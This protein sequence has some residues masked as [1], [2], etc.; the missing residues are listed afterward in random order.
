MSC[1]T[2]P[3]AT[4]YTTV[5]SE[6]LSTSFSNEVTTL[7]ASVTTIVSDSCLA[8]GTVGNSTGCIS[9][10]EVTAVS[11]IAAGSES[12][13][14]VP[15]VLTIT[16]TQ[17]QATATLYSTSCSNGD[18]TQPPTSPPTPP[19]TSPTP[20][21]SDTSH[22]SSS[23]TSFTTSSVLTTST[24]MS[25]YT[26]S[27]ATTLADGAVVTTVLTL[28]STGTPTAVYVP[29]SVPATPQSN[30]G[31]SGGSH[32]N[33]ALA[34]II[35]GTIGGVVGLLAL[36]GIIWLMWRR[37]RYNFDDIFNDGPDDTP[38]HP[39]ERAKS[40]TLDL[41][42]EPK[43]YQYGLVGASTPPLSADH[44]SQTT[45]DTLA[46]SPTMGAGTNPASPNAHGRN[47]SLTP[48]M[49][50]GAM[51]SPS[52][53]QPH[54]AS[55]RP[56]TSGSMQPLIQ[57]QQVYHPG[58]TAQPALAEWNPNTDGL[59]LGSDIGYEF[60]SAQSVGSGT[61]QE[62]HRRRMLLV[63]NPETRPMSPA[64]VA[65]GSESASTRGEKASYR[66]RRESASVV[67]HR[68]GGRAPQSPPGPSASGSGANR[69]SGEA[70][71]PAYSD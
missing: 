32:S 27:A 24:P 52:H 60:G 41:G 68:D 45:A 38:A 30:Q 21:P 17:T 11:T 29:T 7:P 44:H 18:T 54:T 48:L 26:T 4:Q 65:A 64:S 71:P 46:V 69:G 9:S 55:S 15:A 47:N 1:N 37:R 62:E 13:V 20:P 49:V 63:A 8:T 43:P 58:P 59:G 66:P 51:L 12:T 22:S 10:T 2:V 25:T 19:P 35:G 57:Q 6:S 39:V 56:S 33:V 14:Q 31:G 34:P 23:S 50:T 53:S 42:S 28:T 70:P 3:T 40:R 61:A 16:V 36:V 67:V 5:V